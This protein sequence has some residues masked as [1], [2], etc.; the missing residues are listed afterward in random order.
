MHSVSTSL[1]FVS[2]LSFDTLC[3][4]S[5]GSSPLQ[6]CE[7]NTE[8]FLMALIFTLKQI[9]ISNRESFISSDFM[10]NTGQPALFYL[11]TEPHLTMCREDAGGHVLTVCQL[12]LSVCLKDLTFLTVGQMFSYCHAACPYIS[13]YWIR[14][15]PSLNTS[16]LF[17]QL[18]NKYEAEHR[19]H[20]RFFSLFF[21]CFPHYMLLNSPSPF[22]HWSIWQSQQQK[23]PH[24]R[25][26]HN[27]II[28]ALR[29]WN[30][31]AT[32]WHFHF[33]EKEKEGEKK[34]RIEIWQD[35]TGKITTVMCF[36][37][38][39]GQGSCYE[40]WC[41]NETVNRNWN[42]SLSH[43]IKILWFGLGKLTKRGILKYYIVPLFK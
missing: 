14:P 9:S 4:P 34:R 12:T 27:K 8:H 26:L 22:W 25:G 1:G 37:Y 18:C 33:P 20:S 19:V 41:E 7:F 5:F 13:F 32:P 17:F 42:V 21:W 6:P 29:C 10:T 36:Q 43:E 16:H 28:F 3:F 30:S 2:K 31:A 40:L 24:V 23:D 38:S 39:A 35:L 15:A 11:M